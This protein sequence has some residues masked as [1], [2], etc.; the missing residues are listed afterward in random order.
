MGFKEVFQS[1]ASEAIDKLNSSQP[2]PS[3]HPTPGAK[4][5]T[6]SAALLPPLLYYIALFLLPPPPPPSIR[7]RPFRILRDVL[8][9]TSA[10]LFFRLPIIYYVPQSIGLCYQL[11]LVGIY[12]GCRVID[13]FFISAYGFGVIPKRVTYS[14]VTR[15]ETPTGEAGEFKWERLWTDGGVRDPFHHSESMNEKLSKSRSSSPTTGKRPAMNGSALKIIEPSAPNARTTSV[16]S[17][18]SSNKS[19]SARRASTTTETASYLLQKT[20]SGPRPIP[21]YETATT[22]KGWPKTIS[23]RASWALELELSMRGQGFT[24]TTAD[25]R[26][27]R[28]TWIPTIGNRVHSI[29]VHV[30]P[31]QL[32]GWYVISTIYCR[33]LAQMIEAEGYNPFASETHP[34]IGYQFHRPGELFDSLSIPL[35]LVLTV[36]LGSFLMS[37]FSLGHSLFAIMLHPFRPHPISFFPPLYTT[38]VWDLTSVRTFWSFGWHRL[39]AR[40]FLV[41]GVWPGEWAERKLLGKSKDQPAD[42]GKVIG[43]FASSAFVHAFSVRGVLAGRWAEATGEMRFFML[44]G[45]AVVLEGAFQ[46][47]VR[48]VRRRMGWKPSMW[49]DAWIGR[50][51]WITAIAWSG[52]EFARGW[53]KSA[54]V[55]EMAG[56]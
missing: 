39:F 5:L 20:L 31:V 12:G 16:H 23:D 26:H 34:R 29:L 17:G 36:A 25:V 43:A 9:V 6:V 8:A 24:W 2:R 19:L 22:E 48:N 50:V 38:R 15:P 37:A 45:F 53:V 32:A 13:A 46:I 14:Q 30:V 44:N 55:R 1:C 18:A 41:W 52:R 47:A 7:A 21:V 27:T 51:W 28:K 10:F 33:Y 11:G 56:R 40:L 35:Q 4:P 49:Y 54:L 3:L 42:V